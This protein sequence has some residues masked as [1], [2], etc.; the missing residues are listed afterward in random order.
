MNWEII[1]Q[2][3]VNWLT[4]A[5][6]KVVIALILL[7]VSFKLINW[8]SK[9]IE[10]ASEKNTTSNVKYDKTLTRTLSNIFR[11]LLKVIVCACVVG[12]LGLDTS[13]IT[14][15]I[16]SLGVGVGLAVNGTISNFAGGVLLLFTRPF[17]DD[18][19]IEACGYSG[20]VEDIYICNTKIRTPDNK[21]VYIPNGKLSTC[22]VVNYSEKDIRRVDVS[23]SIG[24]GADFEVAKEII[25]GICS[26]HSLIL[27]DPAPMVRVSEHAA[28]SIDLITRVWCKNADYWTVHFDLLEQVKKAF[29]E[30][31]IEIP[32]PQVDVHMR[33]D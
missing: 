30:K 29:D 21:V 2:T 9:K 17:K 14:A 25:L 13:G 1:L 10:K 11:I 18:D 5:G 16:A 22:E 15:L 27:S 33:K 8:L 12:Y 23:F 20:T 28:S 24:Y 19:F 4:T 7:F 6:I 31:G 3:V 32:F 26:N